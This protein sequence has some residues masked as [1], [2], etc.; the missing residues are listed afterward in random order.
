MSNTRT[1][2]TI[3]NEHTNWEWKQFTAEEW[4]QYKREHPEDFNEDGFL[5]IPERFYYGEPPRQPTLFERLLN[6]LKVF[7]KPR[8]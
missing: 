8:R 7:F 4:E 6:G 3:R 5:P 1:V 2:V